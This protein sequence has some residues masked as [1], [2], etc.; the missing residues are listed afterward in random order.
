ML[1]TK[2]PPLFFVFLLVCAAATLALL[3]RRGVA[4]D[5]SGSPGA[6]VP[7]S[8][9]DGAFA[10]I[11]LFT[12]EGCSSCPP[13]DQVLG[14]IA[15]Q[16][17]QRGLPIFAIEFHVDYWNYLGW[18]DPFS[19]AG[20]SQRQQRYDSILSSEQYTPQAVVNGQFPF[21]GSDRSAMRKALADALDRSSD[22]R[23]ALTSLPT[24]NG[25]LTVKYATTNVPAGS[26]L[27]LVLVQRSATSEVRH[28]EN[29]GR[30]LHHVNIAR[31]IDTV[32][33]GD[34]AGQ[35]SIRLPTDLQPKD[36][37][38]IGYIQDPRSLRVLAAQ[39]VDPIVSGGK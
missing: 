18:R 16:A 22:A 13:A 24:D 27:N 38:V 31:S 25:Q 29:G 7:P 28:G 37:I 6:V 21:V 26:V 1:P 9:R 3:Q 11:E 32:Q 17:R 20:A 14:G 19:F 8:A 33:L 10:V 5:D 4:A 35:L 23:L 34:L 15:D 12:S 39:A 30:T 36:A 2:L